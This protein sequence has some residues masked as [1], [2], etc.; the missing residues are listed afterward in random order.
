MRRLAWSCESLE[1][2]KGTGEGYILK[3]IEPSLKDSSCDTETSAPG[4]AAISTLRTA[5]CEDESR[6]VG[7]F[8]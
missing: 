7:L 2:V 4:S 8:K 1:G 5:E 6:P 3:Q